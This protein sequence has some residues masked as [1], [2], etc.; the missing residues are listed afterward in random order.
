[1][2][3]V[4]APD[5]DTASR[6]PEKYRRPQKSEFIAMSD[7]STAPGSSAAPSPE[8]AEEKSRG[9]RRRPCPSCGEF[10]DCGLQAGRDTCWCFELPHLIRVPKTDEDANPDCLCE[11]CLQKLI[12]SISDIHDTPS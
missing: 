10:S 5:P 12:A 7:R 9:E 6:T 11:A 1:M 3:E 4:L 8:N 2:I